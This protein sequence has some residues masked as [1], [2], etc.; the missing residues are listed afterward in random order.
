MSSR[1]LRISTRTHVAVR[2]L[3]RQLQQQALLGVAGPDARRVELLDD[4]TAPPRPRSSVTGSSY[5]CELRASSSRAIGTAS[6]RVRVVARAGSRCRRGGEMTC[7][8]SS[9]LLGGQ[10]EEAELVGQVVLQ[11]LRAAAMFCIA[12]CFRSPSSS[13][14]VAAGPVLLVEVVVPV[15]V[16]RV[17]P[18]ELEV[19][20]LV[21]LQRGVRVE[22]RLGGRLGLV[23]AVRCSFASPGPG[24]PAAP[25]R[26]SPAG[27]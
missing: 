12:S 27:P 4:V 18:V 9:P 17:E 2:R 23:L 11:R 21:V 1:W 10:V 16:E 5:G 20:G 6:C 8:A 3:G 14:A 19:A 25:A 15:A 24:S 13:S 7:S 26:S 22:L